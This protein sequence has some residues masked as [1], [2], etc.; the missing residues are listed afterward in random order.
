MHTCVYLYILGRKYI[1]AYYVHIQL[2]KY[3]HTFHFSPKYASIRICKY[4]L[5]HVIVRKIK[6]TSKVGT[7]VFD[8]IPT[9]T[10]KVEIEKLM[11]KSRV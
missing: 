6:E 4:L 10:S 9:S 11:S 1:C 5:R 8:R 7:V 3:A 2:E